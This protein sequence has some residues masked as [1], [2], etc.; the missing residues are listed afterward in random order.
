M[1]FPS[2]QAFPPLACH[3]SLKSITALLPSLSSQPASSSAN[4]PETL[5]STSVQRQREDLTSSLIGGGGGG[6]QLLSLNRSRLNP[7]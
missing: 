2:T 5:F 6:G 1:P 3:Q 4:F 7:W